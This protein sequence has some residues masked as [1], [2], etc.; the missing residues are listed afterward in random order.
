MPRIRPARLLALALV[1]L[2]LA[3]STALGQ[4]PGPSTRP[5]GSPGPTASP[6]A[7]EPDAL[8]DQLRDL[9]IAVIAGAGALPDRAADPAVP[10]FVVTRSQVVAFAHELTRGGGTAGSDIDRLAAM[11]DGAP[12]FSYLVAAWLTSADT[13][14]SRAARA[15]FP[16][17]TDWRRAPELILPGAALL[18]FTADV[19]EHLDEELVPREVAP[20]LDPSASP[21]PS[22][23]A[24]AEVRAIAMAQGS[25]QAPCSFI[26]A[27]F[28]DQLFTLFSALKLSP[29]FLGS[30]GVLGDVGGFVA[31]LWNAALDLAAS[32]IS[33]LVTELT[34]PIL[35][36]IGNAVAVVGIVAQMSSYITGW[37]IELEGPDLIAFDVAGAPVTEHV[38]RVREASRPF[39]F[40]EALED[41]ARAS[42]V[43]L[44]RL[45][46]VGAPVRWRIL[47][48]SPDPRT[49]LP[50]LVLPLDPDETVVPEDRRPTWRFQTATD[51]SADGA[52]REGIVLFEAS[53]PR[54]EVSDL[55]GL[56]Q[57][58]LQQ[59][60]RDLTAPI[61]TETARELV[62]SQL[63]G[64][65][66]PVVDEL[67]SAISNAGRSIFEVRGIKHVLV[68]Y[69]DQEPSPA[70]SVVVDYIRDAV[71]TQ[72]ACDL[73][74]DEI[75]LLGPPEPNWG[76]GTGR[77]GSGG[78]LD[79]GGWWSKCTWFA[80]VDNLAP[81]FDLQLDWVG[82]GVDPVPLWEAWEPIMF[83]EGEVDFEGRRAWR[84]RTGGSDG[85]I[86]LTRNGVVVSGA[87]SDFAARRLVRIAVERVEAST[88]QP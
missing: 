57:R 71:P 78:T 81:S 76:N 34:A 5:A 79:N 37:A 63:M 30:G 83:S 44:P 87:G 35:A 74:A 6:R 26:Q 72:S 53:L 84:I 62:R 45:F 40:D 11:P 15:W 77:T 3:P 86:V 7:V 47:G 48:Q 85:Y 73:L 51:V 32:V 65:L 4:S 80:R 68:T 22:P 41:C 10:M 50:Y 59:G 31:G 61:P 52:E 2:T 54:E 13:D 1:L 70:P 43:V 46:A 29:D 42:G 55:L 21:L 25:P 49:P 58:L 9:G 66:Q 12:P 67:W 28:N 16:E 69:H 75:S 14:R 24:A 20:W 60:I 18:L 39:P 38:L 8:A 88:D 17:D 33:A 19:A 82:P 64:V 27:F 36:A 56:G 23:G